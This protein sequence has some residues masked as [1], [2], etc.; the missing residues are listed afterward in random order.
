MYPV[1]YAS[2]DDAVALAVE[3]ERLGFDS[4]WGNDHVSTQRYVRDEFPEP[5]RFFDPF[6]YLAV[7]G[8]STTSLGLATCVLVL[9]LRHPVMVAKQAATLD[10]ASGGRLTLGVGVGAYREEFEAMWPGRPIHRGRYVTESME[11][12]R[13][14]FEERR[15]TYRGTEIRFDDIESY[16]KPHQ[17]TLPILAGGN[18][19]GT[20]ARAA[21]D[22]DGWLPACLTPAEVRSGVEEIR[23]AAAAAGRD[24]DGFR[25]ALQL[26]VSVA[27]THEEAQARFADSQ[28]H[29]HL[30]SLSGSTMRGRLEEDLGARNLVGSPDEVAAQ[31]A[32]YLD[33]GVTEFAGLLFADDTVAETLASMERFSDEVIARFAV[34]G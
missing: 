7:V 31:V 2:F 24:L 5:P 10:V 4:V 23:S 27:D 22:G 32:A 1:P 17:E 14:L 30:R 25:V 11:A 20:R 19:P 28:L 15:A 12:L 33:A 18:A 13:L 3:A 29:A 6:T 8:A 21:L 34:D 26:G 9:P 16:P